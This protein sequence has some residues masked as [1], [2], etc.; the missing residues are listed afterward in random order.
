MADEPSQFGSEQ[1]A[2]IKKTRAAV[3]NDA[4]AFFAANNWRNVTPDGGRNDSTLFIA[5]SKK[6][7]VDDFYV[8]PLVLWVPHLLI[9]HHIPT[10]PYCKQ[11][12]HIDLVKSRWLN[13]PKVLY[14]LTSHKYLDSMLY[15]CTKCKRSFVGYNKRSLQLDAHIVFGYFNYFLGHGYAVDEQLFGFIVEASSTEST[16]T[17][18]KK[19][20][21]LQ[22]N[23]YLDQF[24]LYLSAVRSEKV[25]P[26]LKKQRTLPSMMPKP[27]GD[28]ELDQLIKERNYRMSNLSKQRMLL[29]SA[30]LKSQLD[31]K[32]NSIIKDKD[33]HN[34]HGEANCIKGIGGTKLRKL[35]SCNILS[36]WQLL[37]ADPDDYIGRPEAIAH[38]MP[39][40]QEMVLDYYAK[41]EMQVNFYQSEHDRAVRVCIQ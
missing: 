22:Y 21:R 18:A 8:R 7:T 15:Y 25:K 3:K 16:A 4:K 30:S 40:W 41:L 11:K 14:G 31:V 38:L 1:W 28:P 29:S 9:S 26:K 10:C 39:S 32:F 13:S 33:N 24:Q 23:D 6:S 27:S 5:G 34:V 12:E 20:K 35:I 36:A 19:I 17:I 37:D 2:F